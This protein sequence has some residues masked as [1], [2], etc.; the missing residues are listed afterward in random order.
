MLTSSINPL[1]T[2][3]WEAAYPRRAKY[4]LRR[5][6]KTPSSLPPQNLPPPCAAVYPKIRHRPPRQCRSQ[7]R[8][9]QHLRQFDSTYS[10]T[11]RRKNSLT[12]VTSTSF[13]ILVLATSTQKIIEQH[14]PTT[15]EDLLS[16]IY[17]C[18]L[19]NNGVSDDD[20]FVANKED[21]M[22]INDI[23]AAST[24][25]RSLKRL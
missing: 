5:G 20:R 4:S 10:T 12:F 22:A 15:V 6:P 24:L 2:R 23:L 18:C 17:L 21:G 25:Q 16:T 11:L 14:Q 1:L 7:P 3:P 19:H 13:V 8:P 9:R